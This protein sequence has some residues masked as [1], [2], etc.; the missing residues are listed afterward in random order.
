MVSPL[1]PA[2]GWRVTPDRLYAIFGLWMIIVTIATGNRAELAVI[3]QRFAAT[4]T[5]R[6]L[7]AAN[8]NIIGIACII[9][10]V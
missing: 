4:P 2:H 6:N 10:E 7:R 3:V 5:R 1:F 8:A 9:V